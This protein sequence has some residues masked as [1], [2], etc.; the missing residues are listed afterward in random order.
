[1]ADQLVAKAPIWTPNEARM[2]LFGMPAVEGGD[3]LI[4]PK[5]APGGTMDGG[6]VEPDEEPE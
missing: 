5:G 4:Q 3:K 2:R 1:M 6:D